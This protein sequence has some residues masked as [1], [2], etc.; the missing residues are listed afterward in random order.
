LIEEEV[1]RLGKVPPVEELQAA[2]MKEMPDVK[3]S[4]FRR[5]LHRLHY[6]ISKVPEPAIGPP[7]GE[8]RPK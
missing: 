3:Q 8:K 2:V 6:F 5:A 1:D 4:E 7:L